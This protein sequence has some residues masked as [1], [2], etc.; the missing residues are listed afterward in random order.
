MNAGRSTGAIGPLVQRFALLYE[1]IP[2]K[3]QPAQLHV[4]I[5]CTKS[6]ANVLAALGIPLADLEAYIDA[7][8]SQNPLP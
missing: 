6:E 8:L 7:T 5:D 1:S 3:H 2:G 4:E